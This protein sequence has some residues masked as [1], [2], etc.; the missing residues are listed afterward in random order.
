ME[1]KRPDKYNFKTFLRK[2]EVDE[3]SLNL[4]ELFIK[5]CLIKSKSN[6][7]ICKN[8]NNFL[9]IK[10]LLK[11][12]PQAKFLVSIRNPLDHSISLLNQHKNFTKLQDEEK[13]TKDYMNYLVHHEFG[14]NH[15]PMI[16]DTK[17]QSNYDLND[18]NYWLEQCI[19][20]YNFEK[21]NNFDKIIMC[22]LYF[23]KNYVII[24]SIMSKNN[25][26]IGENVFLN[27]KDINFK[28]KK[29]DENNYQFN[30]T[31]KKESI[32]IY[33]SFVS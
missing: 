1:F 32:E 10:S 17:F 15:K 2:Y 18:I 7:Y 12:F 8:N 20:L 28:L 3:Q 27:I 26:F 33:N 31:L 14:L 24:Q 6:N 4:Y 5:N 23:T 11:R 29:Y 19:N 9:R 21:K 30:S 16:L 13:F 25:E 22:F